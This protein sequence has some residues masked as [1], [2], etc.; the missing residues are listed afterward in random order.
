MVPVPFLF[1]SKDPSDPLQKWSN[2]CP[3]FGLNRLVTE[4]L[5]ETGLSAR[6]AFNGTGP[7]AEWCLSPF[8]FLGLS[9][10]VP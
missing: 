5:R 1:Q 9:K 6:R 4:F 8:Y 2:G 10:S 7:I 3:A